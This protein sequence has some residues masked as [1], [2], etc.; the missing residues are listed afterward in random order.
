MNHPSAKNREISSL[1]E[2][3]LMM[4]EILKTHGD[5]RVLM[6]AAAANPILA[7]EH[8]GYAILPE[9]RHEIALHIRFGKETAKT[10]QEI[11]Q[12]IFRTAGEVFDLQNPESTYKVIAPILKRDLCNTKNQSDTE[13]DKI[14]E[15]LEQP[16]YPQQ[17]WGAT[18]EDPLLKY[19][20]RHKLL[21]LLTDYRKIE[22]TA[23]RLSSPEVFE[24]ILHKKRV[25]PLKQL[26][27][28]LQ[29][30]SQRRSKR[31]NS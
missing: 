5:N 14:L 7:L 20:H 29:P 4:P 18:T 31:K 27:F 30:T 17:P 2:L 6:L 3:Q 19:R 11:E 10:L 12:A 8:L 15:I 22:S 9:A 13:V 1:K 23:P 28:R 16:Y 26:Q 21:E 24:Q 25:L